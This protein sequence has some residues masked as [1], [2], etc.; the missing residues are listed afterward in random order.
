M[1]VKKTKAVR[2]R[3]TDMTRP[4]D[5]TV[6]IC[7]LV[8]VCLYICFCLCICLCVCLCLF[9][10]MFRMAW[11][12]FDV[13]L[14]ANACECIR[15]HARI[16]SAKA[17]LHRQADVSPYLQQFASFIRY[18]VPIAAYRAVLCLLTKIRG[19]FVLK[20]HLTST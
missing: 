4:T 17:V 16:K 8:C 14:Y 10:G 1:P 13:R 6:C 12:S 3:P 11:H 20:F 7:L 15:T 9:I 5:K 2:H 19:G 18:F